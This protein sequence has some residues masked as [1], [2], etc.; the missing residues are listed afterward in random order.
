M[1]KTVLLI[2]LLISIQTFSQEWSWSLKATGDNQ[3]YMAA[4]LAVDTEGNMVVAGYFQENLILG[5]F[6]L[7][8]P[9]DYFAD[10]YLFKI[11]SNKEIVWAKTFETDWCY[12]D[13]ISVLLDDDGFIYLTGNIDEKIFVAKFDSAGNEVWHNDFDGLEY[14]YGMSLALDQFDNV[15]VSGGAGWNFFMAKLDY[16]G[17]VVWKRNIPFSNSDAVHVTD[18]NVDRLGNI[19]FI[20]VFN[21]ETL[22]L[23]NFVLEHNGSWGQ[24]T[25][26]GKMD[27]EGNFIWIK[28]SD[29]RTN[30]NPQIALTSTGFL[31]LS[32]AF[33]NDI[34]FEGILIPGICCQNP[35]PYIAKYDVSG[36]IIWAQAGFS[37]YQ[38]KGTTIDME[39]DYTGNLYLT[40]T[41]F[42][43]S[44]CTESDIYLEKYN[45]NGEHQW[46]KEF[47]M[48]WDD[49]T[50][51]IELDN[52]GFA[53]YI[54]ANYSENF[55]DENLTSPTNTLGVAQLNT[56]AST[57]KKTPRP[58]IERRYTI[59]EEGADFTLGAIGSNIKWY[60]DPVLNDL[61]FQ[62]PYYTFQTNQS[63]KLYVTQTVNNIESWPKEVVVDVSEL[64]TAQLTFDDPILSATQ[65]PLFQYQWF[66]EDQPIPN[67]NDYFI[68]ITPGSNYLDYGVLIHQQSCQI[69][70]GRAVLST[71]NMAPEPVF[72]MYPN[73]T[74]GIITLNSTFGV[75]QVEAF[76][77]LGQ[78]VLVSK[79]SDHIDLSLFR[80]GLYFLR[81]T[82]SQ[83]NVFLKKV[84][85]E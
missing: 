4:D 11:N 15:Y 7:Y 26:W 43:C 3:R 85:K 25:F 80:N 16:D 62:G 22:V 51:A 44:P 33:Y 64:D 1:K 63:I 35:K 17:A 66:F 72:S 37:T 29:G 30:G 78:S 47:V 41:Y 21:I 46:R 48:L 13:D 34:T 53:Y 40:G 73:P 56:F 74:S 67:A 79:N 10:M 69:A 84:L 68:E 57:Y 23:D 39:V 54:G 8:T 9:D 76:N 27:T 32:G 14:G 60:A 20:G 59:C 31:F 12:G 36:N 2:I 38:E 70:L 19:Y 82:D 77:S 58:K 50:R 18:I 24:D 28:S 81:I 83:G 61:L 71:P 52:Y 42:T 6:P 5:Q 75:D 45:P 49:F 65:N 55:I